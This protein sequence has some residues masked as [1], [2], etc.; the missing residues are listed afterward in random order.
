[1]LTHVTLCVM[2]YCKVVARDVNLYILCLGGPEQQS[3]SFSAT[4]R[5]LS[6]RGRG[7][8][9]CDCASLPLLSW[10]AAPLVARDH[11]LMEFFAPDALPG[12]L[13]LKV[14]LLVDAMAVR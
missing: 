8:D 12:R 1:M 11:G 13:K 3:V 7:T 9:L 10:E 6:V 2:L 14:A 5:R 4:T